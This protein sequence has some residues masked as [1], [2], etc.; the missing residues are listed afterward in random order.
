M[1]TE[2]GQDSAMELEEVSIET[3]TAITSDTIEE[4]HTNGGGHGKT[5]GVSHGGQGTEVEE[6]LAK[7]KGDLT[8]A[9]TDIPPWYTSIILGFQHYLTMFGATVAIP[10]LL[11]PSLCMGEDL[12]AQANLI[13]TIFFVSGLATLLQTTFGSRLPIVQGGTFSF[14]APTFALLNLQGPCPAPLPANATNEM[15]ANRTAVWQGRLCEVQGAIMVASIFQVI[16]GFTGV[17]G[18]MLRFIG[19]LSI[20]PTIA[21]VGLSLFEA[22]AGFSGQHWGLAFVTMILMMLFSQYVARF[23]VPCA[24]YNKTKSCHMVWFPLFKLFPVILAI[25]G[26]WLFAFILTAAGAFPNDPETYGYGAR[27]DIRI[28][29][30]NESPWFRFP[31]PGQ[32]GTP[33]VTVAGVFGMLA[34][35]LASMI[36]SVGDYYAAARLSGAPPPPTH[37]INR[38]IGMEGI[39]CILAGAWGSGN[40]TTSYSENIGALGITKVGSRVVIQIGGIIMLFLG[41]FTKFGALFVTI[42]DPIIGGMFCIMFGMVAAVGISNLQFVDL[43]SSRNLF[44]IGYSFIMGL[45]IP[46]WMNGNEDFINTGVEEIDQIIVVLLKTSMF[47]GGFFGFFLD[48]TIPGTPE[49]RGIAQWRKLYGEQSKETTKEL[50]SMYNIPFIQGWIERT[51]WL[52]YLPFSPTFEGWNVCSRKKDSLDVNSDQDVD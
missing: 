15:L 33:R 7:L 50:L 19:P 28:G 41:T 42:P 31:Y 10:L 27:T 52:K 47:V 35:V 8:Y 49:E 11:A 30:L 6:I 51:T 38:G 13:G 46:N 4:A 22:A 44:I 18:L 37:A 29:V 5:N 48:N 21:L 24:G 3:Q 43:N 25:L 34:G 17:I 1:A 12:V 36:E 20:A 45:V 2:K 32:W 26:S 40:G 23:S 16:I 9:I 14:L 39:G